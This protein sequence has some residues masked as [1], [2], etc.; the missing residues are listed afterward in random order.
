MLTAS[1]QAINSMALVSA[2]YTVKAIETFSQLLSWTLYLLCQAVD[3]RAMQ[4]QTGELVRVQL[5]DS[6]AS[7]FGKWLDEAEQALLAKRVFAR[8]SRR[9]D[10]TGALVLQSRM[11]ES[12]LQGADEVSGDEAD[13]WVTSD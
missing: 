2:R 4:R 9:F 11:H 1:G 13:L 12:Y 7:F 6:L 10:E 8:I 5:K 3:L